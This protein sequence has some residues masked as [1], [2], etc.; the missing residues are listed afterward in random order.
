MLRL[1]IAIL[2][3]LLSLLV[4]IIAPTHFLWKLAVGITEFPW[5]FMLLALLSLGS[6]YWAQR[7][8]LPAGLISAAAF[9]IFSLPVIWVMVTD[10]SLDKKMKR[11]F[12]YDEKKDMMSSP[13]S[14][15]RLFTGLDYKEIAPQQLIYKSVGEQYLRIDFY[16]A[17]KKAPCILVIH[18]GSWSSGDSR[19]LPELNSYLAGKGYH[20]AAINYRLAPAYKSP[21]Q[22]EDTKDALKYLK[23]NAEELQID[24]TK[25]I[26]LGRSAGGQIALMAAY[27]LNDPGIC[28]VISYYAPADMVWG[29]QIKTNKL[30]LN[31][32]Q[33]FTDYLGGTYK[34]VSE[35]FYESSPFE[36]A[37]EGS[38]PT[39]LIHGRND[40]M[41]SYHHSE[42]LHNKLDSLN[43]KNFLLDLPFA[44]HGCDYNLSG[45]SGQLITYSVER[46]INSV[47]TQK[48]KR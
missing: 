25:F 41:V 27:T 9:F 40:A 32:D 48:W 46:F 29:G 10:S 1:I 30:V 24:T 35:K 34:E 8:K 16:N 14:L 28:G 4:L 43:V 26:L 7:Y 6:C 5:V 21:A 2:L 12:P 38:V 37:K 18:G 13:F 20:V 17:Q 3:L 44:T 19:Q 15:S 39:L 47:T 36:Y 11:V 22:V 31:T 33:V 42:H 45:P 23:E